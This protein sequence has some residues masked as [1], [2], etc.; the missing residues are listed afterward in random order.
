MT[1]LINT[2][3]GGHAEFLDL[4]SSLVHGPSL[5]LLF[6]SLKD[7]LFNQFK[8]YYTDKDGNS[9]EPMDFDMTVCRGG[10]CSKLFLALHVLAVLKDL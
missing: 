9:T 3:T 4:H 7:S 10:P 8:V 6:S 5:N 2:D 1:L